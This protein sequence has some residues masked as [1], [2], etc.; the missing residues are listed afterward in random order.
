MFGHARSPSVVALLA[1]G[2]CAPSGSPGSTDGAPADSSGADGGGT[3]ARLQLAFVD[4]DRFPDATCSDGSPG[5][6]YVQPGVG[7]DAD[8]WVIWFQGGGYCSAEDRCRARAME[9]SKVSSIGLPETTGAEGILSADPAV[10]PTFAS[11]TH[12]RLHYCSSDRWTGQRTDPGF[13][14]LFPSDPSQ[15]FS[16]HGRFIV[17]AIVSTLLEPAPGRPTLSEAS[18]V[19]L[20]GSSGGAHG[21]R[22]NLDRVGA[23]LGDHGAAVVGLSDA[24]LFGELPPAAEATEDEE[25]RSAFTTW[26]AALDDSCLAAHPTDGWRCLDAARLLA[27]GH[28]ATPTFFASDQLDPVEIERLG[29][30]GDPEAVDAF[31]RGVRERLR[32]Y[33]DGAF[34]PRARD[35]V[36]VTTDR[37]GGARA[38]RIEGRSLE[39]VFDGWRRGTSDD[40]VVIEAP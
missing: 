23:A 19:V 36:I 4:L 25:R 3:R 34:A 32:E 7:E 17:D 9:G 14:E 18:E 6:F 21:L 40:H 24:G 27:E 39:E 29:F 22:A 16:F 13:A 35:H 38:T 5:A 31:G 10:N 33:A 28:L 26:D 20:T 30:G 1:L 8:R 12:V 37:F 11:W 15:P 2:A